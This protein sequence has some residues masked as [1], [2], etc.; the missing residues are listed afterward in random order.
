MSNS[1]NK[2]DA[3]NDG[4]GISSAIAQDIELT[5]EQVEEAA[6][7]AAHAAAVALGLSKDE[8]PADSSKDNAADWDASVSSDPDAK[9]KP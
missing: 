1:S 2:D 6:K 3:D 8:P 7:K 4:G 5:V 9:P